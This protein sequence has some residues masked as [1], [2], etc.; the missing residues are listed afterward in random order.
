MEQDMTFNAFLSVLSAVIIGL[1]IV[2]N[3]QGF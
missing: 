3:I 2:K 1:A